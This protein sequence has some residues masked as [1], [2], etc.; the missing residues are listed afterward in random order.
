M[1][2]LTNASFARIASIILML[3]SSNAHAGE[4]KPCV[5][6]P[7][8]SADAAIGSWVQ[9]TL[10]DAAR[11]KR[12]WGPA[13]A[14]AATMQ[15]RKSD[16][17]TMRETAHETLARFGALSK[18]QQSEVLAA[19]A[20]ALEKLK[21]QS[22]R[23]Q[24]YLHAIQFNGSALG[25]AMDWNG[26]F[27]RT[28]DGGVTW[29][30]T[31]LVDA[32]VPGLTPED[33]MFRSMHFA[34]DRFGL[35]VGP[36]GILESRD[37]GENWRHL[38]SH[39]FTFRMPYS[40][41]R[42]ALAGSPATSQ[43]QSTVVKSLNGHGRHKARQRQV[44]SMQSSLSDRTGGRSVLAGRL[45]EPLTPARIGPCCFTTLASASAPSISSISE[46]AGLWATMPS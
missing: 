22:E 10:F 41:M 4:P 15:Q 36:A 34:D 30:D 16:L 28:S 38:R 20:P 32:W 6:Q 17:A 37:G 26:R 2:R 7:Q 18:Q 19:A 44:R 11:R 35:I 8:S 12:P 14:A 39:I 45:P 13:E 21:P 43:M 9:A 40:A 1:S 3:T 27:H 33:G 31:R 24:E 42:H 5:S 29:T 23:D 46:P 25:W